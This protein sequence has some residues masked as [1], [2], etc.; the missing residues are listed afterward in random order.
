MIRRFSLLLTVLLIVT[1]LAPA[2]ARVS[3]AADAKLEIYITGLNEDTLKW[4]KETAFPAFQ[5]THA[6]TQLE[7]ITGGWGDFDATVAGWMSTGSG[8]DIVYLGSEYAATYGK[9]LAD[10]DK[11]LK[12][13]PDLKQYLPASLG[14]A[15]YDGHLRGLPLL[16]SPRPVFYRKDLSKGGADAFKAPTTFQEALDFVKANTVVKDGKVETQGFMDIGNGLFDA[17]EFIAYIWSA[18]GELYKADGSSAF[19]SPETAEAIQFMYDRRRAVLPTEKTA[20]LPTFEGTPLA[21]GKVISGIFPMWNVPPVDKDIWKSVA[22]EP[23]P[24]G[25]NGKQL[26]QVFT[27]WLSVPAYSKNQELAAEFLKFIGSKDNALAL[28]KV[29]GFT[30]VRQDAWDD[31]RKGSEVWSRLLDLAVKYGRGFSD[32]RA[33]AE[34]RPMLV[35]QVTLFLTDQQSLKDTQAKLKSEYDAI[36][37][38]NGFLK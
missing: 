22:I 18:G 6:N 36:L 21:S 34:L 8:P 3:R 4:F 35:E 33:S 17:Q 30:P 20:P 26:I 14:T 13:W 5:K 12:D 28:N 16:M 24:A 25:K 1:L 15:T 9:L 31:I 2:A 10:M 32:I 11:Y 7:I 38:K 19:D 37:K 27:D 29:A 23:Y